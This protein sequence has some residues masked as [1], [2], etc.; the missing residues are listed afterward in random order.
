MSATPRDLFDQLMDTLKWQSSRA[1]RSA[2][3]SYTS[4]DLEDQ[5]RCAISLGCAAEWLIRAVLADRN[6]A[7]L[8]DRRHI[9]SLLV[10][11]KVKSIVATDVD[12]LRTVTMQDA[13][14][15][16][17]QIDPA[18]P[19]RADVTQIMAVRNG[20]VHM[21]FARSSSLADAAARLSRVVDVLLPLVGQTAEQYW[22]DA[23]MPVAEALRQDARDATEARIVSKIAAA[24][25]RVGEIVRGLN[26]DQAEATLSLLESRPVKWTVAED[27][28]ER[29]HVC[30]ACGRL[31]QLTYL[32]I[33]GDG[34]LHVD[35]NGPDES[36]I[37]AWV[38]IPVTLVPTLLQCPVCGFKLDAADDE[39][40]LYPDIREEDDPDGDTMDASEYYADQDWD[41]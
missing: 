41:D 1:A 25:A 13:V 37:D 34:D 38:Y 7:L 14:N 12:E 15:L 16:L 24:V 21:A 11:T 29:E 2:V 33:K 28:T 8:A 30:P 6:A 10:F 40:S 9:E 39:F 17:M 26:E 3:V 20:A 23:L 36:D 35:R 5:I 27:V 19:I 22:G 18:L 4:E 31:A 32:R